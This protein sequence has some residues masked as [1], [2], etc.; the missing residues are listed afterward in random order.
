MTSK[1]RRVESLRI[2]L[3]N[4]DNNEKQAVAAKAN[5]TVGNLR[6]I[7]YGYTP[8]S[9]LKAKEI[10]NAFDGEVPLWDLR[11]DIFER[12]DDAEAIAS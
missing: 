4:R 11:P 1:K 10:S 5:T 7:A 8:V 9:A 2:A 3:T 12:P 6:Q